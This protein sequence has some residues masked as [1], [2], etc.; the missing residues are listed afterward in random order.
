MKKK[1]RKNIN[2]L[3]AIVEC[4]R[5][6]QK[7]MRANLEKAQKDKV[8]PMRADIAKTLLKHAEGKC[9]L[10][11]AKAAVETEAS[12]PLA[13]GVQRQEGKNC[14]TASRIGPRRI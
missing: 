3:Q 10:A 8:N 7:K 1:K 5:W 11:A 14:V 6:L 12:T 4:P 13:E 2:L 9:E